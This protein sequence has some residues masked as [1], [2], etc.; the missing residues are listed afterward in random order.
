MFALPLSHHLSAG[1][2]ALDRDFARA[3]IFGGDQAFGD[4]D[5]VVER[6]FSLGR[7]SREITGAA[8][9]VA[10]ADMRDRLDH[11]AIDEAEARTREARRDAQM[12][13][14]ERWDR[15]CESMEDW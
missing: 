11:P 3:G 12:G 2:A 4:D 15:G 1:R 5:E 13:R 10:A 9:V 6:V 14:A 7:L 8:E